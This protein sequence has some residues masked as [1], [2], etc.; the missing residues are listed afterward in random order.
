MD[1]ARSTTSE[2][3]ERDLWIVSRMIDRIEKSS[4]NY[5]SMKI[6]EA[7]IDL[8]FNALNDVR[9]LENFA[10]KERALR[11]VRKF[12][13]EW[14]LSLSPV[15]PF[16]SEEVYSMYGGDGFASLQHY[17][18]M[19][20]NFRN[21]EYEWEFIE[22]IVEDFRSITKVSNMKPSR[23]IIGTAE[24]WKWKLLDESKSRDLKMMIKE[25][26][27]EHRD[28]LLMLMKKKDI[29]P[30]V[31]NEEEVITKYKDDLSRY[32]N[33]EIVLSKDAT[34]TKKALPGRPA[35]RLE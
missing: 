9:D 32:L 35:I 30:I 26:T 20:N 29:A 21:H 7:T 25:A 12:A 1:E 17:P 16:M 33:V 3:D 5:D 19:T 14:A 22:S 15:I 34:H 11:A 27:P 10:G 24:E 13:K 28:F 2:P 8:F 4:R 6:R 18:S 23:M 31:R